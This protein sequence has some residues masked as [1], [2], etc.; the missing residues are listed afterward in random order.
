MAVLDR[1]VGSGARGLGRVCGSAGEIAHR[2]GEGRWA[3]P[4][5][6][7]GRGF[8]RGRW[9]GTVRTASLR[10]RFSR[11]LLALAPCQA[12]DPGQGPVGTAHDP[13]ESRVL[14]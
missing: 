8:M 5:T 2:Q 11:F 9:V 7:P 13:T 4:P 14:R 10:T 1:R 6:G 3:Q 12:P